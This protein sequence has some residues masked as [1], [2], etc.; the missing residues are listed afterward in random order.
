MKS[1]AVIVFFAV[2]ARYLQW[3]IATLFQQILA[4]S[5]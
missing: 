5:I 3:R 2:F 4:T 1:I